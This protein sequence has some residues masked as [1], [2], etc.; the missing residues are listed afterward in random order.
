MKNFFL[1]HITLPDVFTR[2][3]YEL[4]PKHRAHINALLEQQIVLSYSLD[5]ERK[6][7]WTVISAD[8]EQ[9]VMDLLS[10]FPIITEVRVHIHELA[11]YDTAQ[12]ALP[13]LIMN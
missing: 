3:F 13:D 4:I 8:S 1:V 10:D 2:R 7:V 6:H 9:E 5:I 11:F 12:K